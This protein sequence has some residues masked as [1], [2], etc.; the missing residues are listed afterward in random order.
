MSSSDPG[1]KPARLRF[2][3]GELWSS[4][5]GFVPVIVTGVVPKTV[6]LDPVM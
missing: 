2:S 4:G 5:R 1:G 3:A 6:G